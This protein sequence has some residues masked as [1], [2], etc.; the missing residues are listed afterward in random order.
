MEVTMSL[1]V[2]KTV[3]QAFFEHLVNTHSLGHD[4]FHGRD[5]WLRVLQ[6]GRE[7]AAETGANL[8]VVELFAVLH[9]SQRENEDH[10]PEHG[11]RAA[12]YAQSLR[13]TWF[14]VEDDEME[15]L[16]EACRYHSDGFIDADLTVQACWD[17]D[18]L[19][20]GRVGV[21]PDPRC[22]CTGYAK[23]PV[24]VEAAY[25]RSIQQGLN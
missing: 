13:G 15:L 6:N 19:D 7:I 2:S 9:D 21:R 22:L 8:R 17:A 14:D 4:G 10:D 18:R 20:L 3:T 23:R 11:H 24:I 5:H 16:L 25:S 12:T 1:E